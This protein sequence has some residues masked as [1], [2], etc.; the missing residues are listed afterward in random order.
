MRIVIFVS[1]FVAALAV[2]F[3]LQ[4]SQPVIVNFINWSFEASLVI[5]LLLTFV[6][7]LLSAFIVSI[8]WRVKMMRDLSN[9]RKTAG[10]T[11]GPQAG[12]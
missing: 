3:A 12:N 4:N 7:G 5:V 8:P 2:I 10:H 6:A 9:C 11:G 1:L